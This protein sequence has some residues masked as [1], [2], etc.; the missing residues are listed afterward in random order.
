MWTYQG[1]AMI[2]GRSWT[3]ADGTMYPAQW[4]GRT[5]DSDKVSVGWVWQDDPVK[6][7]NRFY[8]G[9]GTPKALDD[10]TETIDGVEYTTPGL[11]SQ[12]IGQVKTQAAGL[13]AP[14]DWYVVRNAES[15]V[16]IPSDVATYRADVRT[17]SGTI[18]A[19]ITGAAD[20]DAFMA[21]YD[22][23]VDADGVATGNAPINDWPEALS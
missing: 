20:H 10:V 9:N 15:N 19:A 16:A 1:K 18:E 21:L 17:A 23:P 12:A 5:N 13:L 2:A 4:Y 22:I 3:A 14:T 7:D 6:Y 11:K 8:T